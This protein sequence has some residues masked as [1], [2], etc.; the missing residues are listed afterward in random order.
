MARSALMLECFGAKIAADRA[1]RNHRFYEEATELVQA[2]GMTCSE[3]HQL[4]DYTFGRPPGELK[5][6]I[7]V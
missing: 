5:Q 4:V 2:N 6:E 1:E 7:G 3:A